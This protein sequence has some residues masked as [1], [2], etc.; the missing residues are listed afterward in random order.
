ML[1][2]G[3]VRTVLQPQALFVLIACSGAV[4]K[5]MIVSASPTFHLFEFYALQGK[6]SLVSSRVVGIGA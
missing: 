1:F 2:V 3:Q 6:V 4:T 5:V